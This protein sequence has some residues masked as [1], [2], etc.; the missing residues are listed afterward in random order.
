MKKFSLARITA[1]CLLAGGAHSVMAAEPAKISSD[2]LL[3]IL[4]QQG[5]VDEKQVNEVV[6]KAQEKTRQQY[7]S[8]VESVPAGKADARPA[9]DGS[10]VRV[11]YVPQYIQDDIRD[12]VRT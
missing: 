3:N 12:K 2:D 11:P 5:V 6:R 10:V 9:Q 1:A 4:I 8:G 7:Q